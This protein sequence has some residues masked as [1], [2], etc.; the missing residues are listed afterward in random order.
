MYLWRLDKITVQGSV[1]Y[2]G[3][4]VVYSQSGCGETLL[5]LHGFLEE[6]GMWEPFVRHL[7]SDHN[8]IRVDLLGQGG[9]DCLGYVHSMQAQAEAVEAVL[10]NE[11]VTACKVIGHSMGGYVSLQLAQAFPHRVSALM[12][13]H[14]TALPDPEH[15]RADRLRAISLIRRNKKAYIRSVIPSLV[16]EV[17]RSRL[18]SELEEVMSRA[19]GFPE[20]GLVA[21]VRGMMDR[22]SAEAWLNTARIPVAMVHGALDPVLTTA[23]MKRQA[24]GN[25]SVNLSVLE[26]VGHMGHLEAPESCMELFNRFCKD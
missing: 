12:L 21:N 13:F 6:R 14:S 18:R 15:R 20:Q 10:E 9:S 7:A 26:G 19:E 5:L 22:P 25:P 11:Q 3:A 16:A 2:K 8:V 4:R 17:N 1:S 24:A 23:D